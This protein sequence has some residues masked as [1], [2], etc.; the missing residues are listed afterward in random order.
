MGFLNINKFFIYLF[1]FIFCEIV[2]VVIYREGELR[3]YG[4]DNFKYFG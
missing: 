2:L 4:N 1:E 3:L